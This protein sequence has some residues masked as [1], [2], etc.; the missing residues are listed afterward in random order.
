[1]T[2]IPEQPK[3]PE[4]PPHAKLTKRNATKTESGNFPHTLRRIGFSLLVPVALILIILFHLHAI[5]P[6]EVGESAPHFTL[7]T[8]Q[9]KSYTLADPSKKIIVLNFFTTWC[10]PCQAE[11]PALATFGNSF[12]AKAILLLVDRS[13]GAT[14]VSPF[15][16]QFG[17]HH[18]I[19]LLDQHDQLAAPYG[20]T[21][22]PETFLIDAHGVVRDH[23]IGPVSTSELQTLVDRL[24]HS[25]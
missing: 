8:L 14:L 21:G 11:M 3:R 25:T 24:Y 7:P 4:H 20:V 13:E 5:K 23:L 18:A 15:I 2:K 9:G 6:V 17:F 12:H 19:I 1:M 22:Q 10:T 16:S